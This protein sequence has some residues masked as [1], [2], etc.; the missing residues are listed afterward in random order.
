MINFQVLGLGTSLRLWAAGLAA[1]TPVSVAPASE[2]NLLVRKPNESVATFGRR[3]L[4]KGA[5]LKTKPVEVQLPPFGKVVL[6]LHL[7]EKELNN[8]EGWVLVPLGGGSRSTYR[9]NVLPEVSSPDS[10]DEYTIRSV[11]SADVDHDGRPELCVLSSVY[12]TGSG[13]EPAYL[14][15]AYKW[16]GDKFVLLDETHTADLRDLRTAKAVRDRL[17]GTPATGGAGPNPGAK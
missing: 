11:F 6:V 13:D 15:D 1:S 14:T 16:K 5:R 2:A 7:P 17:K 3:V 10:G 8:Y 9:K 12:H 4:P